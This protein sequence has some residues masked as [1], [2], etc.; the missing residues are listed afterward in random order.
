[1]RAQL[2]TQRR[3][4]D[5]WWLA[6][7]LLLLAFA[8]R[9]YR[10][11]YQ[12]LW[13]D[14]T[15][16]LRF[17]QLPVSELLGTFTQGGWNGPL[18]F[19]L[20]RLWI[21]VAGQTEFGLRFFSLVGGVLVVPL[22]YVLGRRLGSRRLGILGSLLVAISPYLVWYSQ[23]AKMYALL[24]AGALL[25][26]Y[27]YLRA[28]DEGGW[29][30]W[31]GYVVV[32]SLCMYLHLLAVCLIPVQAAV[33]LL[34]DDRR[35]GRMRPWLG[36]MAALI[37]P[38]L[39]FARWEIPLL[40]SDFET[41]HL[42][43]PM[44]Q[45]LTVLLQAFTLGVSAR[46]TLR[47]VFPLQGAA[48]LFVYEGL[49]VP[50]FAGLAGLLLYQGRKSVQVVLCWL[51]LP[52]VIVY[53][54]SLG[55]PIFNVRYLIWIAPAFLLLLGMGLVAVREQS[56]A[57]FVLCL[58]GLL[59]FSAQ[60]LYLQSHIPIKSDLRG[61]AAYLRAHRQPDE[62]ILFLV[63]HVR[64]TF[65]YYYGPAD[66]WVASPS[67]NDGAAPDEVGRR[68]GTAIDEAETVWLVLSESE[69]WDE[70]GLVVDWLE[71]HGHRTDEAAFARVSVALYVLED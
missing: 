21:A 17:A 68:L 47:L 45:I 52:P 69:L 33:F 57:F 46:P 42:F 50:L 66:P 28:L 53:L 36:A 54:I 14:E 27:L 29:A 60:S 70:R 40:F 63:P 1:V 34:Q 22:T 7:A 49:V 30:V 25:S 31:V 67:T 58:I 43:L 65:E 9:I 41:G 12:S 59:L 18:F 48:S 32:T 61:A 38:Y 71:S 55:M 15:D 56:R 11:D 5:W 13:R 2:A 26:W 6:G 35:R 10:L 37:L 4:Q 24:T 19:P 62:P 23:E 39:P 44:S 51:L 3:R 64:H 8:L 16:A 20:L